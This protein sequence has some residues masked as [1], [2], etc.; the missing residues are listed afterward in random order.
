MRDSI[1]AHLGHWTHNAKISV[2]NPSVSRSDDMDIHI[3]DL[4]VILS[5]EKAKQLADKINEALEKTE[6]PTGKVEASGEAR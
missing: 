1:Y 2:G 3:G 5:R 6:A 4:Y